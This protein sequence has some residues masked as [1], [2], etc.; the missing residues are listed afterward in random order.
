[1]EDKLTEKEELGEVD[2][3]TKSFEADL[4][5]YKNNLKDENDRT[6]EVKELL[7]AQD[8]T[9][10]Q[11]RNE[12]KTLKELNMQLALKGSETAEPMD[13]IKSLNNVFNKV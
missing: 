3:S 1:M 9:I 10:T 13:A 11:L 7:E 6:A 5:K 4:E 12:I 2:Q 8:M